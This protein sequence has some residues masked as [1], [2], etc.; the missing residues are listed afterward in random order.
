MEDLVITFPDR[1]DIPDN[2]VA[3][4]RSTVRG[5]E[6]SVIIFPDRVDTP[7]N[8]SRHSDNKVANSRKS[9][10]VRSLDNLTKKVAKPSR[11]RGMEDSVI[12]FPTKI[13][14]LDSKIARS[15][16]EV[17][18]VGGPNHLKPTLEMSRKEERSFG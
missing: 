16:M 8:K 18:R 10:R 3:N 11:V 15:L 13:D 6:D 1:I 4:S 17:Q 14:I 9:E 12:T 2:K 5:M 7:D